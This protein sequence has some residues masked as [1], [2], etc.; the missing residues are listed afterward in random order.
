MDGLV[1]AGFSLRGGRTRKGCGYRAVAT[2]VAV[3]G[4]AL[5]LLFAACSDKYEGSYA[6]SGEEAVGPPPKPVCKLIEP[7]PPPPEMILSN[8]SQ[9]ALDELRIHP[10]ANYRESPNV[11]AEPFVIG[12]SMKRVWRD[13][14]NVTIIR[15]KVE[16]GARV[17]MTTPS[18]INGQP[19]ATAHQLKI[20]DEAFRLSELTQF[21][22]A[23]G[24]GDT[25]PAHFEGLDTIQSPPECPPYEEV[26]VGAEIVL[27][28]KPASDE[29]SPSIG[30]AYEIC[31]SLEKGACGSNFVSAYKTRPGEQIYRVKPDNPGEYFFVVR[32]RDES[33]NIESNAIEKSIRIRS[34]AGKLRAD[35]TPPTFGGI[36]EANSNSTT[37]VVLS[38]EGATDD[39]SAAG[40]IWYAY[41]VSTTE[42]ECVKDFKPAGST[43]AKTITA[44]DLTPGAKYFFVVRAT[45]EAGNRDANVKEMTVTMPGSPPTPTPT[46][47]PPPTSVDPPPS[48]ETATPTASEPIA[49]SSQPNSPAVESD[50]QAPQFGGLQSAR[51]SGNGDVVLEWATASDDATPVDQI[52]YEIC[53][54]SKSGY[55]P[56]DFWA[57][58]E[59][60]PGAISYT[61]MKFNPRSTTYFVVRARDASG[62]RDS[63]TIERSVT[64]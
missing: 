15:L 19:E 64:P 8:E 55:C 2:Q 1:A 5:S 50:P 16:Y 44:K 57:A 59:T 43:Y 61:L 38:W 41:C 32:A 13:S 6:P 51:L 30:M 9:F 33:G 7:P 47:P 17:A 18:P 11:L 42:G 26:F 40:S 21:P 3:S 22:R 45:D 39:L 60:V 53:Q 28:W 29:V 23:L 35:T 27:T 54:S 46:E 58:Y 31:Q 52:V 48:S 4:L 34:P 49:P 56:A 36:K 20:F 24:A 14:M 12:Q 37:E 25:V 62:R 10:S 63:N